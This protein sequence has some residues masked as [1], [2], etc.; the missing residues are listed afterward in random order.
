MANIVLVTHWTGGDVLP[1]IK[2]GEELKR[3]GHHVTIGT[4]CYYESKVVDKALNFVA[5]DDM[6]TY[7]AMN[8]DLYQLADPINHREEC[9]RFQLK[10]HGKARLIE[11]YEKILPYCQAP[12]TIILAR[13][14]SS[15][16]GLLVAEKL[17][18]RYASVVLAPNYF[19]HMDLHEQI[20]GEEL[21]EEINQVRRKVGLVDISSWKEWL[22]SPKNIGCIWPEWFADIEEEWPSGTSCIGFLPLKEEGSVVF[23]SEIETILEGDKPIILISGGSSP[24]VSPKFYEMG[25]RACEV[26]GY[27]GI[28]ITRYED[29]L[30]QPMPTCVTWRKEINLA[31]LMK[32]VDLII[33][34]G[35]MGTLNEAIDAGIPQI[36]L[37]HLTDGPDNASRLMKIG[38]AKSFPIAFWQVERI[39]EGIQALIEEK[40]YKEKCN[41]IS[42]LNRSITNEQRWQEF[43]NEISVYKTSLNDVGK[44]KDNIDTERQTDMNVPKGT[45]LSRNQLLAIIKR[46]KKLG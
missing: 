18:L 43:I 36:I 33:H 25:V 32:R 11:E 35:G 14:R 27:K 37:P 12:D 28:V 40:T 4:H 13:H 9:I 17:G 42:E 30:P 5:L 44:D 7:K 15:I 26:G 3:V 31:A 24:M 23:D 6:E 46:N 45:S 39:A 41:R 1:F 20:F 10:Y 2:L 16:S 21:K 8:R 34:H 19:S 38:I 29:L 22:Y